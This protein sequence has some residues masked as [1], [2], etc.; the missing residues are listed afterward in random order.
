MIVDLTSALA[1]LDTARLIVSAAL[2]TAGV[3]FMAAGVVGF[4]RFPDAFTRLHALTKAD[5]LGLGLLVAGLALRAGM[6]RV[7]LVLLLVWVIMV[8]ASATTCHLVARTALREGL[9]P[10]KRRE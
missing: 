8:V 3:G 2:V 4:V 5:N 1:V 6:N 10:W 7:S 9:S